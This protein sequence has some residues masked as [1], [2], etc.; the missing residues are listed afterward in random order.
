MS[1]KEVLSYKAFISFHG[2]PFFLDILGLFRNKKP[3]YPFASAPQ[4]LQGR[5]PGCL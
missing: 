5:Q 3:G 2:A 4:I 1:T